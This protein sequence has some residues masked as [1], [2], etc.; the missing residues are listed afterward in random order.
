MR[1]FVAFDLPDPIKDKLVALRD[2]G[3]PGARWTT[4]QQWHVTL[5]F[6]GERASD[7]PFREALANVSAASFEM[8]LKSVGTFP[9]KGKPRVLWAGIEAPQALQTLYQ[10]VGDALKTSDYEPET[11]PYNPHLTIARFKGQ[12]P[13]R[14][15]MQV[16][17]EQHESFQTDSFPISDFTLY[18][19]E[20]RPS[21]A[22]YTVRERFMLANS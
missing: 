10:S 5:H 8:T 17:F 1:L 2:N 18:K 20:L 9:L 22:V 6:I 3:L 19:S 14:D 15:E 7:E 13:N 11:R 12:T 21:G 4:R 16:Y